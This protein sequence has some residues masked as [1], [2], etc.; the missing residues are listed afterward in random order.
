VVGT[1]SALLAVLLFGALVVDNGVLGALLGS[2]SAALALGSL[3]LLVVQARLALAQENR[4]LW[5]LSGVMTDGRPWPT[6]GGWALEA[7][8]IL[9]LYREATLRGLRNVVELGPGTSTVLLGRMPQTLSIVGVEHDQSYVRS[10]RWQIDQHGLK[11]VQ[12]LHAPL[13]RQ[14]YRGR[15]VDW[16]S[17]EALA[18]LP[19]QFD[20]LVVDGPPNWTGHRNRAP[21]WPSLRGRMSSGGLV[22]VDDTARDDEREMV[23]EWL[24]EG[25]VS[26]IL[27]RRYFML[28]EVE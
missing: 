15:T 11:D 20:V 21:A 8:A 16:Y 25:G 13:T 22:L 14:A 17:P 6:P 23:E 3:S 7:D 27:D 28:L 10:L 5:A 18:E 19:A 9:L 26:V 4:D 2:A 12:V 24:E 1:P